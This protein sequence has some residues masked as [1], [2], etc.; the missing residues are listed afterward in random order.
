MKTTLRLSVLPDQSVVELWHDGQFIGT[1]T[2]ADGPGV[3]IVTKFAVMVAPGEDMV[4]EVR[5]DPNSP[6]TWVGG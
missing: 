3:R 2:G 1:V 5:I 4:T 6:V